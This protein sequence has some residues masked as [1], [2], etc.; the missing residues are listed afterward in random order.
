[1]A[2]VL[3]AEVQVG[4]VVVQ[5]T[6]QASLPA[7]DLYEYVFQSVFGE[8]PTVGPK[9]CGTGPTTTGSSGGPTKIVFT[10]SGEGVV[11]SELRGLLQHAALLQLKDTPFVHCANAF[12]TFYLEYIMKCPNVSDACDDTHAAHFATVCGRMSELQLLPFV[13]QNVM[14]LVLRTVHQYTT[15]RTPPLVASTTQ[16]VTQQLRVFLSLIFGVSGSTS[17][18][19][20][21]LFKTPA[22]FD[23]VSSYHHLSDQ[24]TARDATAHVAH[25]WCSSGGGGEK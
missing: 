5:P 21:Q 8:T 17:D 19:L 6:A 20:Q 12:F 7:D 22:P 9:L 1:M 3:S 24:L 15:Q 13:L 14:T 11:E 10:D 16:L 23:G 4:E 18:D 25:W 2:K